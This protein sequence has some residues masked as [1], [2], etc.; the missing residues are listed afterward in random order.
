MRTSEQIQTE[1]E[2][3]FG[4]FPPFFSPALQNPQVLENL[5]Q[6]TLSAYV[7]NPL[8]AVFKEKL[9]AYLSR[10]CPVPYCMVCH[11]CSLHFL[12]M[13]GKEVLKLLQSSPTEEIEIDKYLHI[14]AQASNELM[15]EVEI[16][17]EVEE[18]LLYC[19]IFISLEKDA[20]YCRRELRHLLGDVNYQHLVTFIAYVKTCHLWME[21]HPEV[22]L[23]ADKRAIDHLEAL[24]DEEPGLADY[25]DSYME[26]AKQKREEEI[27]ERQRTESA[28]Q[29]TTT[30][31]RGILDSANYA[32]ISTNSHGTI[33]TFNAAAE[34][35]L[36]YTAFEVVGKTT[37]AIF[38]DAA[39]V[40]QRAQE[41][42]QEL[43]T[44]IEPG[45][46]VFVAK[47]RRDEIDECEWTYI[48]KDGSCFSVLLSITALRDN[49]DNITGFL[50]IAS[51]I[52]ERKRA[53][54]ALQQSEERFK[55]F[56]NNS[57]AVAFMKD[58]QGRFVYINESF[59]R[60]FDIK[61]ADW[62]GKTDFDVWPEQ[63]ALQ[64]RENDRA[65]FAADKTLELVEVVP[66]PDG[67]LRHWLSFK[68]P[69]KDISGQRLLGGIAIDITDRLQA[70]ALEEA[71]DK[72][73]RSVKELEQRHHEF[74]QLGELSD[75]LQACKTVEE[76]YSALELLVPPLFPQT[77]GGIFL[78]ND[79]KNLV[80]AVATW[81]PA[82]FPSQELFAP[83]ECW[84]LRRGRIHHT[85]K[86]H[87][88]LR[89]SHIH[90]DSA[91]ASSLC[92]SM[93]A[94]GKAMGVLYLSLL[95]SGEFI[96]SK[97]Q[98][99]VTVADHI[100]LSLA[101]LKLRETL[102]NQ[103][104]RDALTGLFNRRYLEESLERELYRCDRNKKSLGIIMLDIDHFK[105]FNDTFGH[106]AGDAVLRE[107]GEF[108]QSHIRRSD[109][110]CRYGGEELTLILPEASVKVVLERAQ[111]ICDG[112]KHLQVEYRRQLLGTISLSLGVAMFPEHGVTGEAVLRAADA[113]L[114]RAKREGR[115]R[116]IVHQ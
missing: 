61:M 56:M 38:H 75:F 50:G 37:P 13:K 110:A 52:T 116:V 9:S 108:L 23:A 44:T 7:T 63:L 96:E 91:P 103:S 112:V 70:E 27:F 25:F 89:C 32:I 68:F 51:D 36:G 30:L 21:A 24:V 18:S 92:I 12:G 78:I 47:A 83:D 17:S 85:T 4:F 66:N 54:A 81:G 65:V 14:L 106:S 94:Q 69:Y 45:F 67:H 107:L 76:A 105:S 93:T 114:Y 57:P 5:W 102:Q 115:D 31:Q 111:A 11:S 88:K 46:E 62:L 55:A 8:P 29:Q 15:L 82:P 74:A 101:N 43:R 58:E 97:Q 99:A 49:E 35:W 20:T 59:E 64:Y 41:L 90:S 16:N 19:A 80:E 22:A 95:E 113:A 79:S 39:E 33:L 73:S 34:R 77:N 104:I 48:R 98:L 100:A 60:C 10:Y 6:Q 53:A 71:N 3:K 2:A 1:I 26:A 84:A 87:S 28:L 86:A 40:L 72:L 109:I 42:S